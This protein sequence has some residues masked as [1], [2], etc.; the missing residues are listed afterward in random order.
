[1]ML[2]FMR[3]LLHFEINFMQKSEFLFFLNLFSGTGTPVSTPKRL[4]ERADSE[5]DGMLNEEDV[6]SPV[7]FTEDSD[8]NAADVFGF[9][10]AKRAKNLLE[11][12]ASRSCAIEINL[13][14]LRR[15]CAVHRVVLLLVLAY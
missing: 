14:Q 8:I 5:S 7:C 15:I 12:G 1:M 9:K 10:S 4:L 6:R 2:L 3:L 13:S 11:K